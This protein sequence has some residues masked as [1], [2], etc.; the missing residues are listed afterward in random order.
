V[1]PARLFAKRPSGSRHE[2][3]LTDRIS[4]NEWN[5]KVKNIWKVK[6]SEILKLEKS[7][8]EVE[9]LSRDR[10]RFYCDDPLSVIE[11][12]GRVPLPKYIKRAQELEDKTRYQTVWAEGEPRS[13]AAP[14]ASLHFTEE[15]W[16]NLIQ[17]GVRSAD[18]FLHVGRGTYEPLRET[19]LRVAKLHEESFE[20][21]KAE[22][23]KI[24]AAKGV[25]ALGTTACRVVESLY[26]LNEEMEF[27]PD[28]SF[29]RAK[30]ALFIKP[31][32]EFKKV[33]ALLTNFHLPESSLLVLLSV[34]AESLSLT[35]EVYSHAVAKKYR[36]FS[37]GDASIWL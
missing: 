27:C 16:N 13:S 32:Y 7:Q 6:D 4:K 19:D 3:F 18:V 31:G 10:V 17:K 24:N 35:K 9:L 30:T 36:L 14:T 25:V 2:I 29:Y 28:D 33:K 26:S 22:L 5:A 1:L 20:V 15:L 34:F 12:E 21:H 37:Y 23:D 11:A 8:V